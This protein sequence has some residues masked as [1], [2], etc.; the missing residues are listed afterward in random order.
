MTGLVNQLIKAKQTFVI[1]APPHQ[2][3]EGIENI[4]VV[5]NKDEYHELLSVIEQKID[6][7]R[8]NGNS[9]HV[10][11]LVVYNL[12]ELVEIM[13]NETIAILANVLEKG[14]KGGYASIVISTPRLSRLVDKAS[15]VVKSYKLALVGIRLNDQTIINVNNK[16]NMREPQLDEQLHYYVQNKMARK[17]K[18][19][20]K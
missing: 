2:S 14:Q 4:T 5:N 20:M 11:T 17:I 6:E 8:K 19:L 3:F 15:I 10:V 16:P 7:R 9:N 1:I 13:D 18:V 12:T